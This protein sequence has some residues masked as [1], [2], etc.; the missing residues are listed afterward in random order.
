MQRGVT[1][2]AARMRHRG[3]ARA[4]R[5]RPEVQHHRHADA[6]LQPTARARRAPSRRPQVEKQLAAAQVMAPRRAVH[7]RVECA[8]R[9]RAP[10]RRHADHRRSRRRCSACRCRCG[11]RAATWC[12][13]SRK[14]LQN[15]RAHA[16]PAQAGRRSS[17]TSAAGRST[18]CRASRWCCATRSA[19]TTTRCA[20]PGSTPTA[21]SSTA[22]ACACASKARPTRRTRSRSSRPRRRRT[23][24]AGRAPRPAAARRS[25]ATASA[26]TSP[27]T[28]TNWPTAR[29][30]WA[31][32]G[33]PNSR[34]A[35]CRTASW[36]PA[37]RASFDGERLIADTQAICEAQMRFWHGDKVGKRGGPKPPHDRYVFMLNAVDDGYGG[38]E[39]RHST[40]LICTRRD[41]PQLGAAQAARGLHH[42]AG[43]DQPRVLPHLERQAPAARRV[44]ALRLRAA[45]TTRS[46]C[47]SSRASPAT[48]TTCCC[49]A[50]AASTTRPT[51][52]LLNKTINQVLQTPGRLVQSVA[53]AS[54][55]A[56][57]K[58]YRQD[59]QTPNTTVSYYTKGALVALCFDLTLRAEGK[60]TLDDVMR[61]L[62]KRSEGGPID[63]G[64][65]RRRARS[66]RRPLVRRA[67]SR[68]W[69]HRH[70]R[71][72]AGRPAARARRRR[73]RRPGAARAGARPAR[74]R[75]QRQ[76]AGQGGA[77][78]RRGRA[79]RL[80]GQRRMDRH[81]A[82]GRQGPAGPG[83]A[84]RASSTTWRSTWAR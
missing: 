84:P 77:A 39:H 83:L 42:A 35:A 18:A 12:A 28:T 25:T 67:R 47:G 52:K 64:R 44:R 66:G 15:L 31:P 43:P 2:D 63:R 57:V 70:R 80:R 13:S 62:W 58:Y 37:R 40:A 17:S 21:A 54:F 46:C 61:A 7:Y 68:S 6:D 30:R 41:L 29:S 16:G 65:L 49:A 23:A 53:Q 32:S 48:T 73:A 78:R 36:S 38:L 14:N 1:P 55:D 72:A 10:V 81:R 20:P 59:E 9:A 71:A 50:P 33:A 56:W 5:I 34:P 79:G 27:P 4:T 24:R 22:P 8:D 11:F 19:P 75:D 51:C 82:A 69:V 26:A 76:R 45:R 60:G 3:A 74:G